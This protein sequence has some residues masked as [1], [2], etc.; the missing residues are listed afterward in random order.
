MVFTDPP[1]GVSIGDKNATLQSVQPSGR[2]TEN[3]MNDTLGEDELYHMLVKAFSNL[4]EE[5]DSACSYYVAAPPGDFLMMM[6]TMMKD[7]G[8]KVRHN[9]MWVKNVA[10][11]SMGHLDY[12]Y[13]HEQI[14]YTWTKKH[15]F[16]G[17]YDTT[18][19]RKECPLGYDDGGT[20]YSL[21][22]Q[23]TIAC[24]AGTRVEIANAT[25]TT[26]SGNWYV[27]ANT[28]TYGKTT[29]VNTC[30]VGTNIFNPASYDVFWGWV[31]SSKEIRSYNFNAYV[32][33]PVEPNTTYIV[34]GMGD[35]KTQK[36]RDV[37]LFSAKPV[38]GDYA[39]G[40]VSA[41][42]KGKGIMVTTTADTKYLGVFVLS[43][44][45]GANSDTREAKV[46]ANVVNLQIFKA[47]SG[48]GIIGNAATDH[49]ASTDCKILFILSILFLI[50]SVGL[51]PKFVIITANSS[52]PTRAT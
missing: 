17:G 19:G 33:V 45:D 44:N 46:A 35:A 50:I 24:S 3:I 9:L 16:Y 5:C 49:D 40:T 34:S 18:G 29:S 1:Y 12:D 22:S 20:G 28:V 4:R 36:G 2:I 11:F 8:L 26:P 38:H 10:T 23:C 30:T 7:A 32:Y 31:N 47:N 21:Q 37:A 39:L 43:D 6:L 25:C 27:G 41:D 51:F 52:P 14:F 13:R 15:N 42:G 48:Y